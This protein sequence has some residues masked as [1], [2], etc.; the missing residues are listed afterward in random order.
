MPSP[1]KTYQTGSIRKTVPLFYD[2][3]DC[4]NLKNPKCRSPFRLDQGRTVLIQNALFKNQTQWRC[5]GFITRQGDSQIGYVQSQFIKPHQSTQAVISAKTW[6]KKWRDGSQSIVIRPD[7]KHPGKLLVQGTA[8]WH[9]LGDNVHTG[10]V[11][12][13][14][15]PNGA[16]MR[17]SEGSGQESGK[18]TSEFDCQ[19][20][21][22]LIPPFLVAEDNDH[23]GGMNVRFNGLYH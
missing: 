8:F 16:F 4:P 14:A 15:K 6:S 17:V 11:D 10:S 1:T 7:A 18:D 12:A 2:W 23:C 21:L 5:I 22:R 20:S 19:L 9:G 3:D 13:S